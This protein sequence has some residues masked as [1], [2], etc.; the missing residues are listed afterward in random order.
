V[1]AISGNARV[2]LYQGAVDLRKGHEG[3]SLLVKVSFDIPLAS[4]AYFAFMN[5]PR[6]RMKILYWDSDGLAIW[7]KRLEKGTYTKR[8]FDKPELERREFLMLLEGVIPRRL[9]SRFKI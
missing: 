3:L 1:I 5:R 4:G 2:F 6:N 9:Q 8:Y 7:F